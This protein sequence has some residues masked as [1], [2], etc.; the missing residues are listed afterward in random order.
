M[1]GMEDNSLLW[2]LL[3]IL[4]VVVVYYMMNK[5]PKK[6]ATVGQGEFDEEDEL[7]VDC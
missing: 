1:F 4:V 3:I 6:P 2:L 5:A 7:I